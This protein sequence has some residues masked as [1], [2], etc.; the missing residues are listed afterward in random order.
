MSTRKLIHDRRHEPGRHRFWAPNAHL[1][2]GRIGQEFDF[3]DTLPELV[4]RY[5]PVLEQSACVDR[6]LDASW[7]AVQ[8]AYPKCIL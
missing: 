5:V 1:S 3:L 6:G 2:Y 7:T 4:E 8:E